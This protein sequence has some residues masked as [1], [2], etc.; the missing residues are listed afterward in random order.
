MAS[1][2]NGIIYPD[3]YDK[4][5]DVPADMKTLAESVDGNIERINKN[6]DKKCR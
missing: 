1:T 6:L 3:N 4:V 5:A 2:K